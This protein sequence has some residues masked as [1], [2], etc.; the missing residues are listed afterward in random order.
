MEDSL[1][2]VR[3][4]PDAPGANFLGYLGQ[5]FE[6]EIMVPRRALLKSA[7]LLRAYLEKQLDILPFRYSYELRFMGRDDMRK[8]GTGAI[9]GIKIDGE[10]YSICGGNGECYL[11]KSVQTGDSACEERIDIRRESRIRTDEW[12]DIKITRRKIPFTLLER[13]DACIEF[14]EL[15]SDSRMALYSYESKPTLHQIVAQM[16]EGGGAATGRWKKCI[17]AVRK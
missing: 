3:I 16:S 5:A 11:R 9:S 17:V 15:V 4:P 6:E 10:P 1:S 12:G 2:S 7:L 14:L 8:K 13:L